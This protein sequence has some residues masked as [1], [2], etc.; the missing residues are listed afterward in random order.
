MTIKSNRATNFTIYKM[1]K[2]RYSL[3]ILISITF[4]I[5]ACKPDSPGPDI[6][7]S[8]V[9]ATGNTGASGSSGATGAQGSTG[10][11]GPQGV[12]GSAGATGAV[13]STGAAGSTG[14]TGST[15]T[16]GSTGATGTTGATGATGVTN[17]NSYLLLNQSVN[18]LGNTRFN[19]PQITQAI[20]DQ[21]VILV[22]V[23]T[24]GTTAWFPLPFSE[25]GST[26][27]VD[28]Y[29]VGYVEVK[30]NFNATGTLDFRVVL[31]AGSS[32]TTLMITHP[33]INIYNYTQLAAALHLNN[34]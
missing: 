20:V 16:T 25:A 17:V 22:Y 28:N 27:T 11:G 19:I 15:G 21:G 1:M 7:T 6:A 29:G 5:Y 10:P 34:Q 24:S 26:L 3:L 18:T 23:R 13:G 9:G 14:A 4:G 8:L 2:I 33:G 12:A 31:I 30:A 32:L